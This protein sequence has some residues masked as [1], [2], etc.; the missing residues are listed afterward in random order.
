MVYSGNIKPIYNA[1]KTNLIGLTPTFP[2]IITNTGNVQVHLVICEIYENKNG[3]PFNI[4]EVTLTDIANLKP[5]ETFKYNF[6]KTFD[7]S[8]PVTNITMSYWLGVTFWTQ[9]LGDRKTVWS[10]TIPSYIK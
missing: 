4:T 9:N 6:T 3:K 1:N 2:A 10:N 7:Y 8:N 5:Q